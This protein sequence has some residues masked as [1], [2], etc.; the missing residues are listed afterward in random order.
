MSRKMR[1]WSQ[2]PVASL[3]KKH[4]RELSVDMQDHILQRFHLL[5]DFVS[6]LPK[7]QALFVRGQF[8][9][10][11][12]HLEWEQIL[13]CQTIRRLHITSFDT[14][15]VYH[16]TT[17]DFMNRL[18]GCLKNHPVLD[19]LRFTWEPVPDIYTHILHYNI[20]GHGSPKLGGNDIPFRTR[21]L[22]I[23]GWS[24]GSDYLK[25]SPTDLK[26][27][28]IV[29]ALT[30]TT[31]DGF[32]QAL[33][34]NNTHLTALDCNKPSKAMIKYLASYRGLEELRLS[35]VRSTDSNSFNPIDALS[36]HQGSLKI[37]DMAKC[38]DIGDQWTVGIDSGRHLLSAILDCRYLETMSIP[39]WASPKELVGQILCLPQ[40]AMEI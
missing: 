28:K 34:T 13:S 30:S 32:W 7:L 25:V 22:I 3:I 12:A 40:N 16:R 24:L 36:I 9:G 23:E 35:G 37:L 15:V 29:A 5:Y 31:D 6:S 18:S 20:S 21:S 14:E 4:A 10:V 26:R 38:E 27:L 2:D 33:G 17:V 1:L 39:T 19:E 8:Q 11:H